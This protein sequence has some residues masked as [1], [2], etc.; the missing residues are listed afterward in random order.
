MGS[1]AMNGSAFARIFLKLL[2]KK[3]CNYRGTYGVANQPTMA[4]KAEE[5]KDNVRVVVR[6]R[7]LNSTEIGQGCR[8]IVK[9]DNARGMVSIENPKTS[10]ADAEPSKEFTF[11]TVFDHNSI[12]ADVYNQTA[13]PIVESVLE[14]YNGTIFAYGQT[15][16][17]KTFTMEGVRSEPEKRGII[18]NS[19]AH[20]FDRI[21][22]AEGETKFLVRISYLEIYCEEVRDLLGDPKQRLEVKERPDTGVYVKGLSDVTVKS[23]MEMDAIMTRGNANRMVGA[24]NM[25]AQSSRSHAIFSIYVERQDKGPNGKSDL[26][27][28]GKLHLVDL[29]GSERQ[30]KTGAE[31]Q[32]LKEA[33]KINLSL[34]TLGNVISSLVDG[35]KSSHVPY[36]ESKLTRLL[37]DSLGG[38]SKTVMI[39]NFGPAD[40]NFDETISTLRYA[41]RA[42]Q[43]KNKPKVNEDPKDAMLYELQKEIKRIKEELENPNAEAA[44][45]EGDSSDGEEGGPASK[46]GWAKKPGKA[47]REKSGGRARRMSPTKMASLQAAIDDERKA[48]QA[49]SEMAAEEKAKVAQELQQRETV[50]AEAKAE[51]D[52]LAKKLEALE[53]K[54]IVGGENLLDKFAAQA[55][56]LE[57]SNA[58]LERHSQEEEKL[59][60]QM[61][62]IANEK[63]D[64]EEKYTTLQDEKAGKTK[65][66]QKIFHM[67]RA[68]ES[69]LNDLKRERQQQM[70]ELL[71]AVKLLSKELRLCMMVID[72]FIPPEYQEQIEATA[73][74]HE[75]IGDWELPGL[76]Y[77]GNSMAT[78]TYQEQNQ[79]AAPVVA[80]ASVN[81]DRQFFVYESMVDG[82]RPVTAAARPKTAKAKPSRPKSAKKRD[83]PEP[84]KDYPVSRPM[85]ARKTAFA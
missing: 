66:L 80:P 24:T 3:V 6:C 40:Y 15:G 52:A 16:T 70:D 28:M 19:F 35:K 83:P 10:S 61:Q 17:G 25:N 4:T 34:T 43:I 77:A 81:L 42:K 38:N 5:G 68:A 21:S 55:V 59:R 53:N 65:N 14:G 27:R 76:A 30:S 72:S 36:R 71:D 49:K 51:R 44:E 13:R 20:I 82:D 67:Q 7:P 64:I 69:E 11:D 9:M 37:Q 57:Q 8:M 29:A 33:T 84:A 12:Q 45:D 46:E 75:D 32:R 1:D 85:T 22:K 54:V 79:P 23:A 60:Q 58:E 2:K 18:P 39:A 41:N 47:K 62:S 48:L 31:G 26:V 50:L 63:V 56:L 74:W 73:V 78:S